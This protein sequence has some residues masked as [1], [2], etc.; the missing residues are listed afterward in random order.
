MTRG[1]SPILILHADD[2]EQ[3]LSKVKSVSLSSGSGCLV[4][5]RV[6]YGKEGELAVKSY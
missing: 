2:D 1:A 5:V 3:K 4:H 6:I